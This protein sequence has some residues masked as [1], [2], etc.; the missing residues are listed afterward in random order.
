MVTPQPNSRLNERIL[1]RCS[2]AQELWASHEEGW[3]HHP[4]V[5][6]LG[7]CFVAQ[8]ALGRSE[9]RLELKVRTRAYRF[10]RGVRLLPVSIVELAWCP[11]EILLAHIHWMANDVVRRIIDEEGAER[12]WVAAQITWSSVPFQ[13]NTA[14][15]P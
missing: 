2:V 15:I 12:A 6:L 14:R 7:K 8:R 13:S 10:Y 1:A 4:S 9:M 11:R 5:H 3:F